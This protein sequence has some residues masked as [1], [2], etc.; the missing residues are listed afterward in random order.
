MTEAIKDRNRLALAALELARDKNFSRLK[1][2]E[3][4]NLAQ[5]AIKIGEEAAEWTISEYG[6]RDPR[7]IAEKLGIKV[8]GAE[9]GEARCTEYK[10]EEK[11]IV[12]FRD[13]LDHMSKQVT[14]PD[15]Q[16]RIL[17]IFI[18]HEL[19]HHL[20]EHKFG[21]IYKR[22][23]FKGPFF[24]RWYIKGVSEIA[25]QSFVQ[26]LLEIEIMPQVFD[27]LIYILFT[28]EVFKI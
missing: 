1:D 18:A 16:E 15:I 10:K 4:L 7:A 8:Y 14:L 27:Y 23:E 25:A 11:E 26:K 17:R 13:A 20:E 2:E 5:E 28:C 12:I 9:R 6:S 3:K 22:F 21:L 24:T 19:F